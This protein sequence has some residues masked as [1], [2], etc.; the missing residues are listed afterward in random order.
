VDFELAVLGPRERDYIGIMRVMIV[1]V[2]WG[3]GI[4]VPNNII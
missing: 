4:I 2:T 3:I 1:E